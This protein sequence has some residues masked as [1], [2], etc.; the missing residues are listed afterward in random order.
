VLHCKL[1]NDLRHSMKGVI[2][3]HRG[4]YHSSRGRQKC[5]SKWVSCMKGCCKDKKEKQIRLPSRWRSC[6]TCCSSCAPAR[7]SAPRRRGSLNRQRLGRR[8][9]ATPPCLVRV[10]SQRRTATKRR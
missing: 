7:H 10:L 3:Q 4:H 1:I 9:T 2:Q 5:G 6:S 8:L